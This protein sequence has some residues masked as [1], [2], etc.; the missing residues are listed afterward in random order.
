MSKEREQ[1]VFNEKTSE[2]GS[3]EF[4]GDHSSAVGIIWRKVNSF[5]LDF[6]DWTDFDIDPLV[7]NLKIT[8]YMLVSIKILALFQAQSPKIVWATLLGYTSVL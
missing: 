4:G 6:V 8:S 1:E 5:F 2:K 7:E 3:L